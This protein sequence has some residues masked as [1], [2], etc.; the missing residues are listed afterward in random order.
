M[1]FFDISKKK[2]IPGGLT[3]KGVGLQTSG[4]MAHF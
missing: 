4:F 3:K 2:N 1:Q